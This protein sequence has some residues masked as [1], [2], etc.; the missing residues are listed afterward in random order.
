MFRSNKEWHEQWFYLKNDPVVPLS[1]FTGRLIKEA[2]LTWPW[3]TP[4]KEKKRMRDILKAV[5]SLSSHNL[6]EASVIGAYHTRRVAPLMARGLLLFG[7]MPVVELS[8]TMLAQGPLHNNKITQHVKEVTDES[9]AMFPILGHPTMRT[10]PGFI[11]L[12]I[13]LGL[14]ASIT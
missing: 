3:G 2:P 7:M 13:D 9:N 11:E 12:S 14:R 6:C 10:E 4:I 8:G 5:T 1:V